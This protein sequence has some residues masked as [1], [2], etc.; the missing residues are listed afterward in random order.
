[1]AGGFDGACGSDS[2]RGSGDP[3]NLVL[4]STWFFGEKKYPI[5]ILLSFYYKMV[6][7]VANGSQIECFIFEWKID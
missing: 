4:K 2:S 1:M 7:K 6:V 3:Y 5:L